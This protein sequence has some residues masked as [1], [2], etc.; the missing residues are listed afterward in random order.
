MKLS[1]EQ[2]K[3]DI[4][5]IV[6]GFF[7]PE[8]EDQDFVGINS[9]DVMGFE[10]FAYLIRHVNQY[11]WQVIVD[12]VDEDFLTSIDLDECSSINAMTEFV[13]RYLNG[14]KTKR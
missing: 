3:E 9:N 7:T 12:R 2:L 4:Q 14:K 13:W 1:K 6:W 5:A 10:E 8:D 11:L